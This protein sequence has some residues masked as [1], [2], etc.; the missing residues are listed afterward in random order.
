MMTRVRQTFDSPHI[1]DVEAHT[2][3][4]ILDSGVTIKPNARIAITAGSRGISNIALILKTVVETVREM[5]GQP[6]IVPAMG[7]HGGATAEGQ[8]ALIEGYGITEEY[9]GAPIHSSMQ[10]TELDS[11]GLQHRLYMDK[12]AAE[13]DGVIVV[14]RI[15]VHTDFHGPIESGIMK[16]CVIGLGKHALAL[17]MHSL[18]VY[19]LRDLIPIAA[20]KIIATGKIL[21]GIGI[22]ENAYDQTALIQAMLPDQIEKTEM[23]MLD[24]NRAHMPSLPLD[25]IDVLIIDRMGKDISG[26]GID[27]NIIGRMRIVGE[28]EPERPRIRAIIVDDLTEG[29]H[30]NAM[31]MGL[32]DFLTKR[33]RDK[34]NFHDTYE[35]VLTSSFLIRGNMPVVLDTPREALQQALRGYVRG[36]DAPRIIRIRDTLSLSDIQL[37]PAAL[38][39]LK[40]AD[41][42]GEQ[43]L[44]SADGELAPW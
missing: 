7:S 29:T 19:G 39:A 4:T 35:N 16:M 31:G 5:G 25:D 1:K 2:R 14:N 26:L 40:G 6:F 17:E 22:C 28:A 18:G 8:R 41:V 9:V 32:A 20:R 3:Q 15:K 10:V 27:T 42:Y 37:S 12:Y 33:L 36:V 11:S 44:F 13:S 38:A 43:P 34:I 30:G 24:W 21:L 23:Q